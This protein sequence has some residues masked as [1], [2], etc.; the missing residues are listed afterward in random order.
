[1]NLQALLGNFALIL[2][3]LTLATGIVWCLDVFY[4]SKQ[5]RARADAALA[6]YDARNARLAADGVP[7]EAFLAIL[8]V[9]G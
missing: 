4:L 2:F 8:Q 3:V 1:M 5:R 6:E 9:E 7:Q